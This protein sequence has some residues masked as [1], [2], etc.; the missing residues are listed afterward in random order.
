VEATIAKIECTLSQPA[1]PAAPADQYL[2]PDIANV[3]ITYFEG[4]ASED[5]MDAPRQIEAAIARIDAYYNDLGN[6]M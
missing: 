4:I 6:G 5:P 2:T 3:T 1:C